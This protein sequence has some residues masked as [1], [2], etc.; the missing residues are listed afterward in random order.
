MCDRSFVVRQVD[1]KPSIFAGRLLGQP[2][3]RLEDQALVTGRA[4]FTDDLPVRRDTLYAA[5]LRSPYP[6]ADIEEINFSQALTLEGVIDVVTGKLVKENSRPFIAGVKA[7]MEHYSLAIDKVRYVGEPVA[8]V[9]AK[10]RYIAEDAL[11]EIVVRYRPRPHEIDPKAAAGDLAPILH[12]GMS[13]NVVSEREFS[14]GAP[15]KAFREAEH[16]IEVNVRYPRSTCTP[17]EC[18]VVVAEYDQSENSYDVLANFQG[19]FTLHPVMALALDVPAN[20]LRLRTPPH[21]GG[22]FGVKQAIFPYI[23]LMGVVSRI[24]GRPVKWVEDRLE[25]LVGASAATGRQS[26]V[27]AAVSSDGKVLA[28]DFD[29][30]EDCGAYLRAPEPASLYRMHGN[31]T[32]AY[33]VA[34]LAVRNRVVLTN[35][36]PSGLNRG[37]GGPQLYFALE[38][39]LD[40]I[41]RRLDLDPIE[42]RRRNFVAKD[43]FPY[44]CAAG[45]LLDSGDYEKVVDAALKKGGMQALL[46][47]KMQALSMGKLY[48]IGC[49][50][51]V[52]PSVSNMG[53][54]TAV[55]RPEERERAGPKNGAITAVSIS[56]DPL[57]SITVVIDSVPQGQGHRTSICQVVAEV[58]GVNLED[59]SVS[60][61]FD[62]ALTNWSIASGNYS[63]RFGPAVAGTAHIAATRLRKKLAKLAGE[64]L[65]APED[66]LIFMDGKIFSRSNPDN[67]V[68]FRRTAGVS[69]W[70]PGL[71]SD[72][73]GATIT[74]TAYWTPPQLTPPDIE[75]RINGS[76]AYGF[77]F[78]FCGVEVDRKT[79]RV[80]IDQY[81][82]SHDAGRIINPELVNGQ[83]RGGFC[84]GVGMALFENFN[85]SEDGQLLAGTFTDYLVPTAC[86]VPD[87]IIVHTE[88]PSP[89]T[90][91]GAKGVGEG[92]SMSTPVCIANAVSDAIGVEGLQLPLTPNKIES[93]VRTSSISFSRGD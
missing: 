7:D 36:V 90:P 31:L 24:V 76:L 28:L 67:F 64:Q 89:Y 77:I 15:E 11:D 4:R 38:T 66:G 27:K 42:I 37:F 86:E 73:V 6:H 63:S 56:L 53:Y 21:S 92:N 23:V 45:A 44:L 60:W 49:A 13:S 93:S 91:L 68:S 69:H 51:V 55:L 2:S 3:K 39:L 80:R 20:Q 30:L 46:H 35:T 59:V 83:I 75:D 58:F 33:Q 62:T 16:H 79:Y 22:S 52:E 88:T 61:A 32:G 48:G 74:E 85:Y 41:A 72:E 87:P 19:P 9:V 34:H 50:A 10:D 70:S 81:V 82:T 84:H 57:G 1:S 78:D 8:V 14:Y 47:R 71:L 17:I 26:I 54:I 65:N 12:Q 18:F 43:S 40:K 25:H 5:I 29:Q